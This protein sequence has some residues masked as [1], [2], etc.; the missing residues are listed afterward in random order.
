MHTADPLVTLHVASGSQGDK[1]ESH[2]D[3]PVSETFQNTSQRLYTELARLIESTQVR[4][5][6][7]VR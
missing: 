6:I 4:E 2:N 7:I 3:T 5:P 1:V